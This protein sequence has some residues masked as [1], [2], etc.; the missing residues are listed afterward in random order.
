M[1]G[2]FRPTREGGQRLAA[3]AHEMIFDRHD[4]GQRGGDRGAVVLRRNG[5]EGRALAVAGDE[6]GDVVLIRARMPRR[7]APLAR[8]SRQVRPAALEGFEDKGLIR[9]DNSA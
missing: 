9:F 3:I 8:R 2:N 4:T 1:E 7:S 5:V 6:D